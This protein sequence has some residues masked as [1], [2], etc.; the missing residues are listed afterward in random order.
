MAADWIGVG[1]RMP[2]PVREVRSHVGR[3]RAANVS[4][5]AGSVGG[6]LGSLGD[7]GRG[8]LDEGARTGGVG[9]GGGR[10]TPDF[11]AAKSCMVC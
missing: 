3:P 5:A 9:K 8:R 6:G 11:G 4:A 2:N 7:A 1:V 10:R